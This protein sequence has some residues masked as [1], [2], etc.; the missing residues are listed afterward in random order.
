MDLQMTSP[1]GSATTDPEL[2]AALLLWGQQDE[3]GHGS[4]PGGEITS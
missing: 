1:S 4:P 2:I 3:R